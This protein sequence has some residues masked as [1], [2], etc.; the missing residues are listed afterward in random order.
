MKQKCANLFVEGKDLNKSINL[1]PEAVIEEVEPAQKIMIGGQ[2]KDSK[3]LI[4]DAIVE[5][6][7]DKSMTQ[8]YPQIP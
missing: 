3:V 7:K 8:S 4:E 1:E 2:P 5:D 6:D